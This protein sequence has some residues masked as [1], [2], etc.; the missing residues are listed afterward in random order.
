MTPSFETD[1]FILGS[2]L[3]VFL[4]IGTNDA[5]DKKLS[6]KRYIALV[7]VAALLTAMSAAGLP[8]VAK[9]MAALAVVGIA[10]TDGTKLMK[11]LT[12]DLR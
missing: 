2:A 6:I 12:Q 11:R 5:L 4:I 7:F 10:L 8:Q 3:V 9:P 1:R